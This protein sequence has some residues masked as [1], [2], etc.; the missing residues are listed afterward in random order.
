M[1]NRAGSRSNS[2]PPSQL[3]WNFQ[4][5]CGVSDDSF[6]R[7][8]ATWGIPRAGGWPDRFGHALDRDISFP[9]HRTISTLSLFSGAG[10]LDFGFRQAGFDIGLAIEIE[11]AFATTL[12]AN[13]PRGQRQTV[14]EV[15]TKDIRDYHPSLD[16]KFDFIIG[17]PPCQPF[18][19]AGRR[20]GG[21]PG[22]SNAT[23]TLFREYARVLRLVQPKAFLFENV[24]GITGVSKGSAWQE[25]RAAFA[26][27]GYKVFSRILDS[28]DYGVPQ[29]RERLFIIGVQEGQYEFPR[30]L[31][32]PDSLAEDS[33]FAASEAISG[34]PPLSND[35]IRYVGGRYGHLLEAIPPGLNYSFYTEKMGHPNPVFSWRSKFSDFLYKAD[36][37]SPV[38]TI[39]A[40]GGLY[41]GPFH[42]NSRPFTIAEL[43]RLQTI[44]DDYMLTGGRQSVIEQIGNSVPPQLARILALTVREQVFGIPIPIKLPTLPEHVELGFR[45]RKRHRTNE[46]QTKAATAIAGAQNQHPVLWPAERAYTGSLSAD[47]GWAEHESTEQDI[48]VVIRAHADYWDITVDSGDR[49]SDEFEIVISG[50][51]K[52]GWGIGPRSV[53]LRGASL[54]N[55]DFV[56]AWKSFEHE[57]TARGLKGDLVQLSGYYQYTPAFTALLRVKRDDKLPP[58]WEV[59]KHIVSGT[60]V[61]E[62]LPLDV[63]ADRWGVSE[64]MARDI[65][66][67]LKALGYEV[68]NNNTNPQIPRDTYLIPYAFPT[69]SPMSVQ[70]R[71]HLNLG[72]EVSNDAT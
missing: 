29:H 32:G 60:G 52:F 57:L 49:S 61:R 25:I 37:D 66:P 28:A 62:T 36:P 47:F 67:F 16:V 3:S 4:E 11:D 58:Q 42:W 14:T 34:V 13:A 45:R 20:A 6:E 43:K 30:P 21:V 15:L 71:K 50:R 27:I 51:R 55:V 2:A 69:L 12:R 65:M 19:A 31:F 41:T 53:I 38:R 70:L 22:T 23:G 68:R 8:L 72:K 10:G 33:H 5:S 54:S 64:Q 7:T 44:P 46:Y 26:D 56:S 9:G 39:K 48:S 63:I 59:V 17:G 35:D 1:H 40:Q 18:S 24:Y